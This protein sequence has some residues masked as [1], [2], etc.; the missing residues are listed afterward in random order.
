MIQA[1]IY[2]LK[3]WWTAA[4]VSPILI[5]IFL[6]NQNHSDNSQDFIITCL[7]VF[8]GAI[9]SV[10]SAILFYL[11]SRWVNKL[12]VYL[13]KLILTVVSTVLTYL[14]FGLIKG[15]RLEF[16]NSTIVLLGS[17]YIVIVA[18]IWLYKLMLVNNES[19]SII[20]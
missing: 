12:K 2:T 18:G 7:V 17:Y 20:V 13:Q 5:L 4:I 16:D 8:V 3:V 19:I 9:Y 11:T 10:P 14:P 6:P 1:F 15:I